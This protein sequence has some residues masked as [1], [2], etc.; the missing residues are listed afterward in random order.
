MAA[1]TGGRKGAADAHSGPGL[2]MSASAAA[3]IPPLPPA[4]RLRH[5]PFLPSH[6]CKGSAQ[7]TWLGHV[8]VRCREHLPHRLRVRNHDDVA[9]GGGGEQRG[10]ETT[11]PQ[12]PGADAEDGTIG[13][14]PGQQVAIT[15][16]AVQLQCTANE[17]QAAGTFRGGE[18]GGRAVRTRDR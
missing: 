17:R 6:I 11:E 3:S 1:R 2:A 4:L 14:G 5:P 7:W 12:Q 9:G 10:S 8:S 13:L 16:G 15:V 18:S